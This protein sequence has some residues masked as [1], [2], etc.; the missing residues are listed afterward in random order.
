MFHQSLLTADGIF[1]ISEYPL[2]SDLKDISVNG[3]DLD[4]VGTV[5]FSTQGGSNCAGP[6]S[7]ANYMLPSSALK[8]A[9][10]NN[11]LNMTMTFDLYI[12]ARTGNGQVSWAIT[13]ATANKQSI[14]GI[15]GH[16]D[17]RP[18]FYT[19]PGGQQTIGTD[20][21]ALN[22]WTTLGYQQY[23]GRAFLIQG[24]SLIPCQN[25][26]DFSDYYA[27]TLKWSKYLKR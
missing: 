10:A 1:P 25:G 4:Q 9:M 14:I 21:I 23:Y 27:D 13:N 22:T 24:S 18:Y 6:F 19:F 17:N 20:I 8:T 5:A 7:T 16:P 26:Q 3:Y 12:T 2:S 11:W 15:Y